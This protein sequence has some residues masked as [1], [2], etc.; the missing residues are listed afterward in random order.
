MVC[1]VSE[2]DHGHMVATTRAVRAAVSGREH[3]GIEAISVVV[4]EGQKP[5]VVD[6][7]AGAKIVR[8]SGRMLVLGG[9]GGRRTPRC[10]RFESHRH[11]QPASEDSIPTVPYVG[12]PF[13][14]RA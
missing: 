9:A 5:G 13:V 3:D 10:G 14:S 12:I 11:T 6:Q 1:V 2:V 8:E 4:V 7:P